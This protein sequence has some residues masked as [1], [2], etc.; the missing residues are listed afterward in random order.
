MTIKP[1]GNRVVVQLVKQKTT[2]ASGII[3]STED[4]NEQSMGTIVTLGKG[5]DIDGEIEL[6]DLDLSVGDVVLFG[7]Y[8]GEEV[9]DEAD[10][11]TIFKIL[12]AKDILAVIEK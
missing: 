4:K 12:N 11:D 3:L 7:K 6:K 10:S 9:K 1:L 5:A 8:S 2:S